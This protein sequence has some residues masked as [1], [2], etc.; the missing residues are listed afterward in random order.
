MEFNLQL[1]HNIPLLIYIVTAQVQNVQTDL[2][3]AGLP[4]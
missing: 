4:L 3:L 2:A 1:T